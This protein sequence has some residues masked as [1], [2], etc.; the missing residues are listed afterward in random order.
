MIGVQVIRMA[1]PLIILMLLGSA[2]AAW[3]SLDLN[4]LQQQ[5]PV[6]DYAGILKPKERVGLSELLTELNAR[7]GIQVG[8]VTLSSL[9]GAPIDETTRSLYELWDMGRN[10]VNKSALLLLSAGDGQMHLYVGMGL[11]GILTEKWTDALDE[12]ISALVESRRLNDACV[13]AMTEMATRIYKK[14]ADLPGLGMG[15]SGELTG[16]ASL[17]QRGGAVPIVGIIA[18]VIGGLLVVSTVMRAGGRQAS[19]YEWGRDFERDRT[20]PFGNKKPRW[21]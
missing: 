21:L 2:V 4:S 1:R 14:S 16:G 9:Q 11:R 19:V 13:A 5:G 10:T 15:M 7:Y 8:L 18:L 20:G 17:L 6:S 12:K 3:G